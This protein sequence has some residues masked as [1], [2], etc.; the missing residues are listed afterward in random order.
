MG[1]LH[2]KIVLF[3]FAHIYLHTTH[4]REIKLYF[5]FF[6]S[7]LGLDSYLISNHFSISSTTDEFLTESMPLLMNSYPQGYY[8]PKTSMLTLDYI[9]CLTFVAI[10]FPSCIWALLLQSSFGSCLISP[11][12]HLTILNFLLT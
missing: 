6:Y 5:G 1:S 4:K 11:C 10:C 3:S 8:S 2:D 7:V 9:L 12:N